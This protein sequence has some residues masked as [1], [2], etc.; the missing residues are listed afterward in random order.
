M[1]YS[2]EKY[3]E[4]MEE[5]IILLPELYVEVDTYPE[6]PKPNFNHDH[7]LMLDS[8]D[9]L[10]VITAR[11]EGKLVGIHCTYITADIYYK[12]INTAFV[13]FYFLKKEN[14]GGGNGTKMFSYAEKVMRLT[15]AERLFISRKIYIDNEKMFDKLGYSHIENN[16]TKF[17]GNGQ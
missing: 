16:Y 8:T 9:E 15:D 17:I 13:L 4:I 3:P 6:K 1:K 7:F 14:R 12:H 2:V 11:E 5:L 10:F